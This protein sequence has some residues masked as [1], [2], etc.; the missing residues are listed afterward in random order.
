LIVLLVR[1]GAPDRARRAAVVLLVVALSQGLIGY[2]QYFTG[3]P[4]VLVG[5]HMLGAALLTTATTWTLLTLR[6]R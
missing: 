2:V 4:E 3:L 5:L 1:T 6:R